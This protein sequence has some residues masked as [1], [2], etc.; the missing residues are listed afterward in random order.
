LVL[1]L[2]V[3]KREYTQKELKRQVFPA[4]VVYLRAEPQQAESPSV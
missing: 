3:E 1:T 2:A 4:S